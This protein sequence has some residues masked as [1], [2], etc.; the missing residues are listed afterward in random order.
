MSA[1]FITGIGTGVGKTLITAG[2]AHQSR[3]AGREVRTLKPIITGY[4][5]EHDPDSSILMQAS[6]Q[7]DLDAVSPWRFDAPLSPHLAAAKEGR[8]IL[9]FDL[10]RF[11]QQNPQPDS[12]TLIEGVGGIMVPITPDYLVLD[13]MKALGLPVVLVSSSYLGAINHTLLTVKT[14]LAE[15]LL[16]Q[17]VVVSQSEASCDA[18]LADTRASIAAF[19]PAAVPVMTVPRVGGTDTPWQSLPNLLSLIE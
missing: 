15:G 6:G 1:Y 8:D 4:A 17:A 9:P 11:C 5:G 16:L 12:L 3:L 7:G 2:L 14:L 13:W 10:L 19:L 18:G